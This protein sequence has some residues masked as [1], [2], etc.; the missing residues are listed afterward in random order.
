M[1]FFFSFFPSRFSCS[2]LLSTFLSLRRH[3]FLPFPLSF[4][5]PVF[6]SFHCPFS[7]CLHRCLCCL[8][9]SGGLHLP[10]GKMNVLRAA[11][12]RRWPGSLAHHWSLGLALLGNCKCCRI[13]GGCTLVPIVDRLLTTALCNLP[14]RLRATSAPSRIREGSGLCPAHQLI[15]HVMLVCPSPCRLSHIPSGSGLP[16][17]PH[18]N[19]NSHI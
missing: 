14:P 17:Q 19:A 11:G 3:P 15:S 18:S 16:A 4:S 2:L 7:F 13:N 8:R 5:S 1:S 6:S 12:W 10:G 9:L